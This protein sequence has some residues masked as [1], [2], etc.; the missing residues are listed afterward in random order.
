MIH[1]I[2]FNALL[3]DNILIGHQAVRGQVDQDVARGLVRKQPTVEDAGHFSAMPLDV[4]VGHFLRGDERDGP[5]PGEFRRR[6]A[7]VVLA[8]LGATSLTSSTALPPEAKALRTASTFRVRAVG[9]GLG[10]ERSE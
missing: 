10:L 6:A 9:V 4:P 3:A 1:G 7:R 5:D 2:S 8:S